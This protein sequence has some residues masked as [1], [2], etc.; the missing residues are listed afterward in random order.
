MYSIRLL[1]ATH[2]N[3]RTLFV[4]SG[5]DGEPGAAAASSGAAGGG[6]RAVRGQPAGDE[7]RQDEGSWIALADSSH[8]SRTQY[9]TPPPS[10]P[11][12]LAQPA[13]VLQ[14][15]GAASNAVPLAKAAIGKRE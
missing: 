14:A 13:D 15:S 9:P 2:V 6:D 11:P 8:S 4:C 5:M 1:N 10:T 12:Y 7:P 3:L